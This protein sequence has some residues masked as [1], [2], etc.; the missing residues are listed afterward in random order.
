[1]QFSNRN[2]SLQSNKYYKKEKKEGGGTCTI[3]ELKHIFDINIEK[4]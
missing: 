4:K 3:I 1:M 2:L